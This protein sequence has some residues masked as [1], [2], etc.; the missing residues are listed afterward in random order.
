MC[1]ALSLASANLKSRNPE[2]ELY[3]LFNAIYAHFLDLCKFTVCFSLKSV[4]FL[5]QECAFFV[6]KCAFFDTLFTVPQKVCIDS[7]I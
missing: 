5:I 3:K 2:M 1:V 6:Y 4:L 7:A